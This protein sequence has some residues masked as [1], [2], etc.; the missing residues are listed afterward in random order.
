MSKTPG[1]FRRRQICQVF[2]CPGWIFGGSRRLV[3]HAMEHLASV[4]TIGAP[5]ELLNTHKIGKCLGFCRTKLETIGLESQHPRF[6][7]RRHT[8]SLT[9]S[10]TCLR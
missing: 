4:T 3:V 2:V 1:E 8:L 6:S 9:S 7:L 5:V 10:I